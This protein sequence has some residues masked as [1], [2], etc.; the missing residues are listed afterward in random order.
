MLNGGTKR[1]LFRILKEGID[2]EPTTL[3]VHEKLTEIIQ[4]EKIVTTNYDKLFEKA[5]KNELSVI[6]NNNQLPL[7]TK[8]VKLFKVHGDIDQESTMVITTSDYVDFFTSSNRNA[9]VWKNIEALMNERSFLFIGYSL[10]DINVKTLFET[11]VKNVGEFRHQSFFVSPNLPHH[12]QQYL[13]SK[14]IAYID[15]TAEQLIYA[16]HDEVISNLIKDCEAGFLDPMETNRLLKKKGINAKFEIED[17]K[18]RLK[19]F[20]AETPIPFTLKIDSSAVKEFNSFLFEDSDK[21]ELELSQELIKGLDSSYN[22]VDLINHQ[23]MA[24]LKIIKHPDR[25]LDGN[26]SLKGTSS[27]LEN[28]KCKTFSAQKE[29]SIHFKHKSFLI[30]IKINKNGERTQT[31]TISINPSGDTFLD[32]KAYCFLRDWLTQGYELVFN[33]LT[34]RNIIPLGNFKSG[35]AED[36]ELKSLQDVVINSVRFYEKLVQIQNYYSVYLD[37]PE[38]IKE[39][40]IWAINQIID[41]INNKKSKVHDLKFKLGLN[42]EIKEQI[43]SKE[44]ISC[45]IFEGTTREVELFNEKFNIGTLCIDVVDGII[46]NREE[47]LKRI[48]RQEEIIEIILKSASDDMHFSYQIEP[49]I[50]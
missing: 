49:V 22:G 50:S 26:F 39:E 28:I 43:N 30:R 5:Y 41:S 36:E 11:M 31:I 34:D 27:M 14:G 16:I 38:E 17:E 2:V 9:A 47:V 48:D 3:K 44:P 8:R 21:E 40:D 45:R 1:E 20:G 37:V 35:I 32:Y 46:T 10:D 33:N 12:K 6:V 42:P 29:V 24:N 23:G 25:E 7:A 18:L 13:R 4:I 15:M 19:S